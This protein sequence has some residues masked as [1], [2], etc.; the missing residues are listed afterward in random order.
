MRIKSILNI[1]WL[2]AWGTWQSRILGKPK[3][4]KGDRK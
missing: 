4:N 1:I 3:N 2:L